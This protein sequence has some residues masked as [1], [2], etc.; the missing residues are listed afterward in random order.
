MSDAYV[1]HPVNPE[2]IIT[3]VD[4]DVTVTDTQSILAAAVMASPLDNAVLTADSQVFSWSNV[5]INEYDLLIGTDVGLSDIA[6]FDTI[7]GETSVNA[8]GLP[9]DGSTIYV[10]LRSKIGS[11]WLFNDYTYT[12]FEEPIL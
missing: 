5:N 10:R 12:A 8:I 1:I 9:V 2:V 6:G 7:T 4:S 3:I 11:I